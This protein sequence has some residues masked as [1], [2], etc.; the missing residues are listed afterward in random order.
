MLLTNCR[1]TFEAAA[2]LDRPSDVTAEYVDGTTIN[3]LE[4]ALV[5]LQS[6]YR[7]AAHNAPEEGSPF[8]SLILAPYDEHCDITGIE[9]VERERKIAARRRASYPIPTPGH[10]ADKFASSDE[11]SALR[12]LESCT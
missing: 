12:A 3:V 8:R 5:V 2:V 9:T 4:R 1:R 11:K 7:L 10:G 6:G